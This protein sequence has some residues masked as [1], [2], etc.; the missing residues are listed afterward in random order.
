MINLVVRKYEFSLHGSCLL[1]VVSEVL[2]HL[3][4]VVF[5]AVWVLWISAHLDMSVVVVEG[6]FLYVLVISGHY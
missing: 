6:L 4:L 1:A 2:D 5:E 3:V